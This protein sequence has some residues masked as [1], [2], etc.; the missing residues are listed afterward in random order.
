MRRQQ[1]LVWM[2]A[3]LLAAPASLNA[4]EARDAQAAAG[5]AASGERSA[6]GA[7]ADGR[8]PA[9]SG[10][11]SA[12][13]TR[14]GR[15]PAPIPDA[16][17]TTGRVT[18]YAL[19]RFVSLKRDRVRARRGPGQQWRVDWEFVAPGMPLEVVA[20]HGNW[21]RVRDIEGHGGWVHHIFLDGRRSAIVQRD[22]TA[23]RARPEATSDERARIEA[24]AI[25]RV[26]RCAAGWCRVSA[27]GADGWTEA[28]SLWGVRPD[29]TF[30]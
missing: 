5:T 9:P 20:E 19:P 3:A 4:Q 7:P 11:S 28:A 18:G 15:G 16:V 8:T 14:G 1:I 12:E 17:Q 25:L 30:E 29:E 23:L 27:G 26:A 22:M 24:G 10:P 6:E 21:R 13:G 2:L